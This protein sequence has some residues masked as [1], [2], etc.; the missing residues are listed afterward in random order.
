MM[1]TVLDNVHWNL[2]ITSAQITRFENFNTAASSR[3]RCRRRPHNSKASKH[4]YG[5]ALCP[6]SKPRHVKPVLNWTNISFANLVRDF[7]TNCD[8]ELHCFVT[9]VLSFASVQTAGAHWLA[10]AVHPFEI[11]HAVFGTDNPCSELSQPYGYAD[12][13]SVW[14][15]VRTVVLNVKPVVNWANCLFAKHTSDSSTN[16]NSFLNWTMPNMVRTVRRTMLC[17]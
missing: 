17:S 8:E 7:S 11:L 2:K 10:D 4:F 1:A 15:Q 14:D 12:A 3:G 6:R 9:S 5:V 13:R 16:Y